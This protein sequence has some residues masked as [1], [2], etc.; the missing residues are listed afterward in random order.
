M[1][2]DDQIQTLLTKGVETIIPSPAFLQ[3]AL[4]SG[5]RLTIYAGFDPTA[6]T[7]HIG[8]AIGLRKLR[9][10]QDLGHNIIFLIDNFAVVLIEIHCS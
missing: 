6:P 1:T 2:T 3:A 10:F 7:L 9:Q 8:H 5:K 4:T